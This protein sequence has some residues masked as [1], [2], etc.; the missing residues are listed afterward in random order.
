MKIGKKEKQG[1]VHDVR[2]HLIDFFNE[3]KPDENE[4]KINKEKLKL[5]NK[6]NKIIDKKRE[7][8]E[9]NIMAGIDV[10][11]NDAILKGELPVELNIPKNVSSGLSDVG[12]FKYKELYLR[13]I[14]DFAYKNNINM[15]SGKKFYFI[16]KDGFK[17]IKIPSEKMKKLSVMSDESVATYLIELYRKNIKEQ[18]EIDKDLYGVNKFRKKEKVYEKLLGVVDHNLN[19]SEAGYGKADRK[20]A[21]FNERG[22]YQ[23]MKGEYPILADLTGNELELY[24]P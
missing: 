16:I 8:L 13:N 12:R 23:K 11:R 5:V 21:T 3:F 15:H 7:E 17:K 4:L 20:L 24:M 22:V 14:D 6:F 9:E 18:I 1:T 19:I 2:G 10:R